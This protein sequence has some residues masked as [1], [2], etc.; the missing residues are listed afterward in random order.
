M[1]Q[2]RFGEF[3]LDSESRQLLRACEPRHISPKAFHLLEVLVSSRPRVW[4]KRE[5]QDLLWPDTTVVEANLP[6]L[7]AEV[8]ALKAMLLIPA[9]LSADEDQRAARGDAV[10]IAA[11]LGPAGRLQYAHHRA[12][13]ITTFRRAA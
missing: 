5:L 9:D 1:S 10:G 13:R 11:R 7:V 12:R 4:S 2:Y 8:R 6:N 3:V